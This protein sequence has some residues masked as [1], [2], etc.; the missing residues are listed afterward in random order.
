MTETPLL[1][2]LR[3]A[4][5]DA[6]RAQAPILATPPN[7][8]AYGCDHPGCGR[9]ALSRRLCNGHYLRWK[10]GRDMDA[11]FKHTKRGNACSVC[12]SPETA[13]GGWGLCAKHYRKRRAGVIKRALVAFKGG[14]CE[15]CSGVFPPAAFDLHHT[16]AKEGS[17][18]E[19]IAN[20]SIVALATE[21]GD[22]ELL[23]ANCHRIE[24]AQDEEMGPLPP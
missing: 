21:V 14:V 7:A 20:A 9:P 8:R 5:S 23:C 12:G 24:H 2:T 19:M 13:K 15:R 17:I 18:S 6:A 1:Q 22:C 3:S 10:N 16:G 4:L 11:P